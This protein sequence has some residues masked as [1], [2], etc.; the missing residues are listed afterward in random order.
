MCKPCLFLIRKMLPLYCLLILIRTGEPQDRSFQL[1]NGEPGP[2]WLYLKI[3][4]KTLAQV[5]IFSLSSCLT[6]CNWLISTKASFGTRK[7]DRA[8]K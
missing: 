2:Y 7:K 3:R 8:S 5:L 6:A 4:G 1:N